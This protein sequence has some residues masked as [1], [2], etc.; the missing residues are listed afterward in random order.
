M[1]ESSAT[2]LSKVGVGEGGDSSSSSDKG[3]SS[4]SVK[5]GALP[6]EDCMRA[7]EVGP[8]LL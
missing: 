4:L 6:P 3:S 5:V 1:L 7:R 8:P 2:V